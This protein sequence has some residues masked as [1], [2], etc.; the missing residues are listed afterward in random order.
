[1]ELLQYFFEY[2]DKGFMGLSSQIMGSYNNPSAVERI[3]LDIDSLPLSKVSKIIIQI[4][5]SLGAL[6]FTVKTLHGFHLHYFYDRAYEAPKDLLSTFLGASVFLLID[7]APEVAETDLHVPTDISRCPRLPYAKIVKGD[8]EALA[9]PVNSLNL[10][11]VL[12]PEKAIKH[13]ESAL[14]DT[15]LPPVFP[16]KL[17][18]LL[19]NGNLLKP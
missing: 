1:M 19:L 8:G 6:P 14:F 2:K 11:E 7:Y 18:S 5:E 10:K 15:P 16:G 3:V 9:V 12:E 13:L 17:Q 4:R